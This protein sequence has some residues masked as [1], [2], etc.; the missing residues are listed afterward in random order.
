MFLH[1]ENEINLIA[2]QIDYD[3]DVVKTWFSEKAKQ[4]KKEEKTVVTETLSSNESKQVEH[5]VTVKEET[6][7]EAKEEIQNDNEKIED[8]DD[9][10]DETEVFEST[11]EEIPISYEPVSIQDDNLLFNL[12]KNQHQKTQTPKLPNVNIEAFDDYFNPIDS[13]SLPDGHVR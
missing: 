8:E 7:K 12:N 5:V 9:E 13:Y 4:N 1:K 3:S 10:E 11:L 2:S 6:V